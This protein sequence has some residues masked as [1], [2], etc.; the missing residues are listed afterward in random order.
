[1]DFIKNTFRNF[2]WYFYRSSPIFVNILVFSPDFKFKTMTDFVIGEKNNNN[3]NTF[4]SGQ[5]S[6]ILFSFTHSI[7]RARARARTPK[8]SFA[9]ACSSG[10][11]ISMKICQIKKNTQMRTMFASSSSSSPWSMPIDT[12]IA[13]M[14]FFLFT[15]W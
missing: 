5:Q 10:Q 4:F 11:L 14:F 1:M 6:S 9:L 13:E 3:N 7:T 2:S 12:S 15:S 8:H